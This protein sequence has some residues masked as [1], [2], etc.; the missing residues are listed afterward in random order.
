MAVFAEDEALV[1]EFVKW[2]G[3]RNQAKVEKHFVPEPRI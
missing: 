2:F 3:G 1:Y